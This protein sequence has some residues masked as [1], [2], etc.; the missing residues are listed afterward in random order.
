LPHPNEEGDA[1]EFVREDLIDR[2]IRSDDEHAIKY[3]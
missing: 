1:A 3:T 2:A